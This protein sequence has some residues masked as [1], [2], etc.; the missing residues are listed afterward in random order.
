M[1]HVRTPPSPHGLNQS[2]VKFGGSWPRGGSPVRLLTKPVRADIE[3]QI[4]RENNWNKAGVTVAF[5]S[6]CG[7]QQ[8]PREKTICI[9]EVLSLRRSPEQTPAAETNTPPGNNVQVEEPVS[10]RQTRTSE[11][12]STSHT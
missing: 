4:I 12:P 7:Q 10:L 8:S 5:I 1:R 3:P 6:S 2:Q 9:A 11:T